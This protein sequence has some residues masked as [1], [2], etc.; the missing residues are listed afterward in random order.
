MIT[1]VGRLMRAMV[2]AIVNVLPEPVTPMRVWNFGTALDAG[3]ELVDRL[4][5][6]AFGLER[7]DDF[8]VGHGGII[9]SRGFL[10]SGQLGEWAAKFE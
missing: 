2:W 6:I 8:E 3:D 10:I 5:L 9:G 7:A 1:S 4:R